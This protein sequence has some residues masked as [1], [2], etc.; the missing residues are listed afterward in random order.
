MQHYLMQQFVCG[1]VSLFGADGALGLDCLL[2]TPET[3]CIFDDFEEAREW[4]ESH[5]DATYVFESWQG[6]IH[7]ARTSHGNW[8]WIDDQV[9]SA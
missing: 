9:A 4:A 7:H 8:E 2:F 1:T 3:V 5:T 6:C